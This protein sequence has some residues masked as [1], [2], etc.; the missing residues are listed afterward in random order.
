[1]NIVVCKFRRLIAFALRC[2]IGF[3]APTGAL[4]AIMPLIDATLA[5]EN[6]IYQLNTK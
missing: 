6:T 5:D 1:M 2:C 3:L 4:N